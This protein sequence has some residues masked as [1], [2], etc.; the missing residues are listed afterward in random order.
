MYH[1]RDC[2][3][4][5]FSKWMHETASFISN[6]LNNT[7]QQF[8]TFW[9]L[10]LCATTFDIIFKWILMIHGLVKVAAW[11]RRQ[12]CEKTSANMSVRFYQ[13]QM[14]CG[15]YLQ[16]FACFLGRQLASF[17]PKHHNVAFMLIK[18]DQLVKCNESLSGC[19][20]TVQPFSGP[21]QTGNWE[22]RT[23]DKAC[24]SSKYLNRRL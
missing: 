18:D 19:S 11:H 2:L 15:W 23:T 1:Q 21:R 7:I 12:Y 5:Y 10:L 3:H 9:G 20:H 16:G 14:G 22:C 6:S 13:C 8:A 24:G 17:R 4:L